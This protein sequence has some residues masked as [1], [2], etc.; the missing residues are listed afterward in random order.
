MN[1]TALCARDVPPGAIL[2][3]VRFDALFGGQAV[4]IPTVPPYLAPDTSLLILETHGF[5]PGDLATLDAL[6]N[7]FLLSDLPPP[8][9]GVAD[10]DKKSE[11]KCGYYE[12]A[13]HQEPSSE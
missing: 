11:K 3:A 10:P 12:K 13:H 9:L 7:P 2:F 5:A 4:T 1:L 8:D 6:L